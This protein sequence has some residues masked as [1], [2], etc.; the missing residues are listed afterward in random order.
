MLLV[1]TAEGVED[2]AR[3]HSGARE[4]AFDFLYGRAEI[5]SADASGHRNHAFQI[6]A[7]DLGL[8]AQGSER[9][10]ALKWKQVAIGCAQKEIVDVA[11]GSARVARDPN[12]HAD[13]LRPLLD[14][15]GYVA[16]QKIIERFS[17]RLR[18]HAFERD[19]DSVHLNVERIPCRNDAIFHFDDAANF[20]NRI[21]HSRSERAQE[22]VV[23]RVKFDFD[24]L[25]HAG[26]IADQIFHQLQK[27]DLKAGN[28]FLDLVADVVHDFFN[29]AARKWFQANE[30]IASVRFGD[31]AA[32]LQ[33]C[34][35]G[36]S[37]HLPSLLQN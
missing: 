25:R 17:D 22:L 31:A 5:A 1:K 13:Q 15:R 4:L 35:P 34:A 20:R 18:I 37:L 11:H 21:G 24:G 14:V 9:G 23:V 33:S 19:L 2:V 3:N 26:E 12:A 27:F 36:V 28:M 30:K 32:E 6:V 16:S 29:S 7:H 10:H 8:A